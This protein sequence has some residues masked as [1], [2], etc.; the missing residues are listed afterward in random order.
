MFIIS[1]KPIDSNGNEKT[2]TLSKTPRRG[3]RISQGHGSRTFII[4]K[5]INEIIFSIIS[6]KKVITYKWSDNIT[7]GTCILHDMSLL[8]YT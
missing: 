8:F 1:E 3:T 7:L 2:D 4:I 6:F 5:C